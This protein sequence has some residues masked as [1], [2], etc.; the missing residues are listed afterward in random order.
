MELPNQEKIWTLREKE[1]YKYLGILEAETIKHQE[2]KEKIQKEYIRRTRKLLETKLSCLNLIKGIRTWA[3]SVV[4]YSGLSL[5]RNRDEL[6][7]MGQRTTKL[8]TM[9]KVLHPRDDVNWLYAWRKEGG[10]GLANI[11]DRLDASTQRLEVCIEKHEGV[12]ITATRND[13][14]NNMDNRIT[15]WTQKMER[16]MGVLN[17]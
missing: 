10:R 17:D 5:K 9:H 2:I 12:L 16:N 3:F 15:T 1:T 11:E 7:Q 14:D 13:T 8:M 6:K 4:R